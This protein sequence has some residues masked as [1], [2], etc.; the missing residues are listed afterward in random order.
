MQG[1]LVGTFVLTMYF[2]GHV[3]G[4]NH[5]PI[6]VSTTNM[7]IISLFNFLV[8]TEIFFSFIKSMVIPSQSLKLCLQLLFV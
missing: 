5:G 7:H 1:N 8:K 6:L 4:R 3:Y 2:A